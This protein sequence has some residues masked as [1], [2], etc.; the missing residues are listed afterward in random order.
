V[1][2]PKSPGEQCRARENLL[3]GSLWNILEVDEDNFG[4]TFI[5]QILDISECE[6]F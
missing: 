5:L 3:Q 1:L 2:W 4:I 6:W